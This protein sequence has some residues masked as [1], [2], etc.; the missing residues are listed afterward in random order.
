MLQ[1]QEHIRN[2]IMKAHLQ[3]SFFRSRWHYCPAHHAGAELQKDDLSS[4]TTFPP[5]STTVLAADIPGHSQQP[6]TLCRKGPQVQGR[7]DHLPLR[8]ESSC[9]NCTLHELRSWRA[10]TEQDLL[11]QVHYW[12]QILSA[13]ST[14]GLKKIQEM[15]DASS[16]RKDVVG[17]CYRPCH[18]EGRGGQLLQLRITWEQCPE[19]A[20]Q[21]IPY[22]LLDIMHAR[23]HLN[24]VQIH[25]L[26]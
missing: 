3:N 9:Q 2:T 20:D 26:L 5:F 21:P 17:N 25:W 10:S 4:R 1:E 19:H 8:T 11:S 15:S 7:V 6:L 12:R 23:I 14:S 22:W 24:A 13:S 16:D 18:L